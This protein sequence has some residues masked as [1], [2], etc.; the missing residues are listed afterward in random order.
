MLETRPWASYLGPIPA[1]A[2]ADAMRQADVIVNNSA[3]EGLANALLEAATLG[4][5]ILARRNPGNAAV[6]LHQHNGLL[7]ESEAEFSA[8]ALELMTPARRKQLAHPEPHLYAPEREA[9]ELEALLY[10]AAKDPV[11]TPKIRTNG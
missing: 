3:A 8:A 5:P 1:D 6:V 10:S 2:M 4:I 11:D 9:A 7:Y